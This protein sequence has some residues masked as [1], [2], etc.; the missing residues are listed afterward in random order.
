MNLKE[1]VN[2]KIVLILTAAL[3][4]SC[5][6][7]GN[8]ES[9]KHRFV[10]VDNGK[11][12]LFFVDESK[13]SGNWSVAV[14]SGT[15]DLQVISKDRILV[16]HGNGAAEF[17]LS[18]GQKIKT[19]TDKYRGI[20]SARRLADGSTLLAS[21]S[22]EIY[23]LDQAGKETS[24]FKIKLKHL[25]IR[26]VRV[27]PTGNF[28]I[29]CKNP[30]AVIEVN[31]KG[32]VIRKLA[33]PGKGYKALLLKTG[34]ILASTGDEVKVLELDKKGA[35]ISFVGGKK[36]HPT[37]GLDFASGFARLANGNIVVSNWLGH[38]KHGTAAHL[39]EYSR[40]NKVV[41]KWENHKIARQVTNFLVLDS[42]E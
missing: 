27:T 28:L 18:D 16:S 32:D 41:W 25:D 26:L 36:E 13:P 37:L 29:G 42:T 30:R 3:F 10:A 11:N 17:R 38:G 33:L 14:P 9:I 6:S 20:Q 23:K 34:H 5:N 8:A 31:Q 22:G 24:R 21:I 39:I 19:I 7:N 35:T 15:R 40:D 12:K 2:K 4:I 1:I